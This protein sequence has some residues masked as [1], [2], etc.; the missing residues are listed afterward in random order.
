M[1][2]TESGRKR[3]RGRNNRRRGKD[4]KPAQTKD[5]PQQPVDESDLGNPMSFTFVLFKSLFSGAR[6]RISA[7][8]SDNKCPIKDQ[9]SISTITIEC[10]E[11]EDAE[12]GPYGPE[13]L[14]VVDYRPFAGVDTEGLNISVEEQLTARLGLT[15]FLSIPLY[16]HDAFCDAC[17]EYGALVLENCMGSS[18]V[19][20]KGRL[21]LS[22][23]L[24]VLYNNEMVRSVIER[25]TEVIHEIVP[26]KFELGDWRLGHFGENVLFIEPNGPNTNE[27]SEGFKEFYGKRINLHNTLWKSRS[28]RGKDKKRIKFKQIASYMDQQLKSFDDNEMKE[29]TETIIESSAPFELDGMV[30]VQPVV[31]MDKTNMPTEVTEVGEAIQTSNEQINNIEE[32]VRVAQ[33][34]QGMALTIDKIHLEWMRTKNDKYIT[35]HVFELPE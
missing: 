21:H 23:G 33:A 32:M 10:E 1:E 3:R 34:L 8:A 9:V 19:I 12:D 20:G 2:P 18:N 24:F 30:E 35:N 29:E 31:E 13:C 22:L 16:D 26:K 5:Q 27:L 14:A 7:M 17:A 4:R 11:I 15:H 28:R 25:V 6:K